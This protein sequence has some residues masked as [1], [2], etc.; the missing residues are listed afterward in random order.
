M[1]ELKTQKEIEV[2]KESFKEI[3]RLLSF[4]KLKERILFAFLLVFNPKV[5]RKYFNKDC[6]IG[7]NDSHKYTKAKNGGK[8]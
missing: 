7:W 8:E 4:Y 1:T 3:F 2:M 5:I 6:F